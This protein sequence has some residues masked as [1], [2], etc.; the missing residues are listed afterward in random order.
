MI[1]VTSLLWD[2]TIL[3]TDIHELEKKYT[4]KSKLT[5][6]DIFTIFTC[7]YQYIYSKHKPCLRFTLNMR[8]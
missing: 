4:D 6:K 8:I 3:E 1:Y 5:R 7:A 2:E